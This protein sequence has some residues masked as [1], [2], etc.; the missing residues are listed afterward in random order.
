MEV[1]DLIFRTLAEKIQHQD[2]LLIT[3]EDR[4]ERA[5]R[6]SVVHMLAWLRRREA[7]LLYVGQDADDLTRQL[8]QEFGGEIAM[9][10]SCSLFILDN[11]PVPVNVRDAFR[12]AC[13]HG[14]ERF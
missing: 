2:S 13:N 11:A 9:A 3:L 7:L 8:V 5:R 12:T 10:V 6:S 14:S 1:Q 4:L